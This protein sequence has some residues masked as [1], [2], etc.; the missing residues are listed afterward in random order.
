MCM[1]MS[2]PM[3]MRVCVHM[4]VCV[5]ALAQAMAERL[6]ARLSHVFIAPDS[7]HF[8]RRVHQPKVTFTVTCTNGTSAGALQ[9]QL[10][11]LRAVRLQPTDSDT[12]VLVKLQGC[13]MT[14]ETI[15]VLSGLPAWRGRF[16]FSECQWPASEQ[17]A[18]LCAQ[19]AQH[20]PVSYTRWVVP[21]VYSEGLKHVCAGVNQR[22]EG[23]GMAPLTVCA[24]LPTEPDVRAALA[25]KHVEL[26]SLRTLAA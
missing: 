5:R 14:T 7:R 13:P 26:E 16:E 21:Y 17:G 4:C 23:L 9:A 24:H 10:S 6:A 8:Q 1:P 15:A 25:G 11:M 3:L 12:G 20:V 19:L 22:R 18:A 2:M